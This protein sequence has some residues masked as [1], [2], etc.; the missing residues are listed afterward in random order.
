MKVIFTADVDKL[1]RIGEIKEVKNGLAR[2]Y[3]LPQKLAIK[4]TAGN[5]KLW[6]QKSKK[7]LAK[8]EAVRGEAEKL[9]AKVNGTK[10]TF[11]VKVGE[12]DKIFGSITAQNISDELAK[13]GLE[14]SR[15][16][17]ELES[18]LKTVGTHDITVKL[19]RDVTAGIVVELIGENSEPE[20]NTAETPEAVDTQEE[21]AEEITEENTETE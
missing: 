4:A 2:N 3:L 12:E 19:H 1:G 20:N 8:E 13:Q 5:L 11:P 18:P 15:K 14:I 21:P 16:D 7:I 17:I 10:C 6:E 9:A